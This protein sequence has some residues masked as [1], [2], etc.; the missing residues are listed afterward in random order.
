MFFWRGKDCWT[1]LHGNQAAP[2]LYASVALSLG[3]L[4]TGNGFGLQLA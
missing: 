2:A 3:C 1:R 4:L